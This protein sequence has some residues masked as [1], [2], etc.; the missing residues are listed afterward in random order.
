[1][2]KG[3]TS[4]AAF[5]QRMNVFEWQAVRSSLFDSNTVTHL[6]ITKQALPV[7]KE[8]SMILDLME[9]WGREIDSEWYYRV[10]DYCAFVAL[11]KHNLSYENL[12]HHCLEFKVDLMLV[13]SV[14][15]LPYDAT[16]HFL[17]EWATFYHGI[18]LY[19]S[20]R[21]RRDTHQIAI[22]SIKHAADLLYC[23][24]T[25]DSV[26]TPPAAPVTPPPV[27]SSSNW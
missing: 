17:E 6:I 4:S 8:M 15:Y 22:R 9:Y 27:V 3:H 24:E 5:A 10:I 23:Q 1:M 20:S 11:E 19:G 16:Q 7:P 13:A 14:G 2:R 26:V 18:F 25:V 21:D 12:L